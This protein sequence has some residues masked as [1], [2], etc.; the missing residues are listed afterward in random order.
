[1][2]SNLD[3][4]FEPTEIYVN[5]VIKVTDKAM[6]VEVD[7]EEHWLPLS[8]ISDSEVEERGESGFLYIPM[9]LAEE[10]ELV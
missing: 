4:R 3:D 9:W 2:I 6:L 7:G 8:Q 5:N 1:L 10:K